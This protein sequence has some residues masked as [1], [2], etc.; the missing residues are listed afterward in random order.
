MKN[1]KLLTALLLLMLA[2]LA[3][4]RAQVVTTE[5]AVLQQ[6]SQNVVIYFHADRGDRGLMDQPAS[7]P[8]YAHTGVITNL[9]TS[10]SDWKYA[11][12]WLDN[13][14]KYQLEYVSENLWRLNIGNIRSYYGITNPAEVV[15]K[16]AFVF[17]NADGSRTGRATTGG[18]IFVNVAENTMQVMLQCDLEDNIIRPGHETVNFTASCTQTADISIAV[19]GNVL[20]SQ[21]GVTSLSASYTFTTEGSY[22]VTASATADGVTVTDEITLTVPGASQPED[23]PGGVPKMGAVRNADGSVTFCIAAP[24]KLSASIVGSWNN[25][26][27]N[28]ESTMKF[29]DYQGD[30]YFWT[31]VKGLDNST[32]Y[33]YY[34]SIDG[35]AVGDPYARL[36]LDPENDKYIPASVFPDLPQYPSDKVPAQT[37]LA[38]YKGDINDYNWQVE[39]FHGVAPQDLIIYE[40]LVRDFTGTEGKALGDGTIRGA[41]EKLPYLRALGVNAIELLPINEFNGNISWGYNPNFYFAPDK[42]YGTP[43]DYKAFIDACHANGM[44]VIL[45]MVFNQTDWQHPWYRLYPSGSNPFYNADAPHAYSVLNDWNQ[46]NKLV[47]QQFK[48]VLKYWITEYKVDGYRFDLVKGL[49][50]NDSYANNG[51]A[52]TNAYNAS[53]VARM[54]KLHDAMREVKADAYFINENLAGAQEENEMAADGELNWANVNHSGG[55]YAKGDKTD[56]GLARFYAPNDQRT[57]GSTVSYLESHDEQRLAY[58]QNQDGVTGVRGVIKASMGR[59][60]SAAA[61]MILSPGAHMIWQFSELGNFENTKNANGGNNTDPKTVRWNLFD[62]A[63]RHG[64][65][66]SYSELNAIRNKN[67]DLFAQ[68]ATFSSTVNS[69]NW[70][71]GRF[72]YASKGSKE[73]ICVINPEVSETRTFTASFK[74]NDNNAYTIL[75]KSYDTT[76]QFDAAT[77]RVTLA[78]NSYV[79][80][81]TT[82][83]VEVPLVA[84]D[85]EAPFRVL[86]IGGGICVDGNYGTAEVYDLLGHRIATLRQGETLPAPAGVYIVTAAG[87]A[88]KHLHR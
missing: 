70:N 11:P 6:N 30:R 72:I 32:L 51:D 60:G 66:T 86:S 64:L 56:S 1:F 44:A 3:A 13:A 76:P 71:G 69:N 18:D 65:Y 49:G 39:D 88:R 36:V 74:N 84:A 24:Q 43:D 78:P 5:P 53:R 27:M 38:V 63:N 85:G 8:V 45:D 34:Y 57:W 81:G 4:T 15:K 59:L 14:P 31:T 7:Q 42:A 25:W 16:L 21:N 26:E 75:S 61:Q 28:L 77:G 17:R 40:L 33:L 80:I 19:A 10:D 67:R 68:D 50:D 73:L 35:T 58:M 52:A 22:V 12:T 29:Q 37:A 23:Y 47:Q 82:D 41:M 55:M 9:S 20:A 2:P 54:K 46:G 62:N 87:I 48:D 83:V 79:V